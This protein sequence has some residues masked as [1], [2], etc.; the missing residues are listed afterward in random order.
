MSDELHIRGIAKVVVAQLVAA[1]GLDG[2][3]TSTVDVLADLLLRYIMEVGRQSRVCADL[4]HRAD[5]NSLDVV[6]YQMYSI[7]N[8]KVS[9]ACEECRHS[10][11]CDRNLVALL[12]WLTQLPFVHRTYRL[13]LYLYLVWTLLA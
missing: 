13:R 3:Q 11:P 7:F 9:V 2:V 8:Q 10:S 6:S 12:Q 5:M 1:H 4:A